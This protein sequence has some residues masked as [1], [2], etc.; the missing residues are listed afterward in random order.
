MKVNKYDRQIRLWGATGQKKIAE[1]RVAL[2]G[3][4]GAGIQA[5]KNLV[6]PAA[7]HIDI[8]DSRSVTLEDLS[9]SFFYTL[10]DIGKPRAEAA[11]VNL[12][13][14]NPDVKGEVFVRNPID[15][16][17]NE[18]LLRQYQLLI[19]GDLG[20]NDQKI[21]SKVCWDLNIAVLFVTVIGFYVYVRNQKKQHVIEF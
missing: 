6:L 18:E 5:L 11:S 4:S 14:M 8:W 21:I 1:A 13:E 20:L 15:I 7:G 2:L 17:Q 16:L 3:C 9:S 12:L 19:V 10:E